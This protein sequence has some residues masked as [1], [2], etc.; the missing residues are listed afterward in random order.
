MKRSEKET[1]SSAAISARES[2]GDVRRSARREGS[3][4]GGEAGV[5]AGAAIM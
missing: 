3:S 1:P 4:E 5:V 2:D